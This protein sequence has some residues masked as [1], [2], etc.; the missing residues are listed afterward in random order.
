V[1]LLNAGPLATGWAHDR[2]PAVMTAWY[3]GEAGGIG[4]A[5]ALFRL[6]NPGGKLPST[7]YANF[8]GVPPQS[9]LEPAAVGGEHDHDGTDRGVVRPHHRRR[10]R[11]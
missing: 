8:D 6:D 4:I 9:V 2:L 11:R 7:V 10:P 5:R 1:V 3:S